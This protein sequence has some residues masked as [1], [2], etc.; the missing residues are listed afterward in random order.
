VTYAFL[1]AAVGRHRALYASLPV[2]AVEIASVFMFSLRIAFI[3][4]ALGYH[5]SFG[6]AVALATAAI[7]ASAVGIFPG[8]LGLRELLSAA[9]ARLV[10]LDPSVGLVVAAVDRFLVYAVLGVTSSIMLA[11]GAARRS[12]EEIEIA[13][14]PTESPA[15][16]TD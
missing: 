13:D 15:T 9:M 6:Q 11:S 12:L 5:A 7:V 16:G 3:L 1:V 2:A 4:P 14:S 10:G 8:G